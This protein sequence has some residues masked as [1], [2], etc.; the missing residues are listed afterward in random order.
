MGK[1][2][3]EQLLLS[4]PHSPG[5][6]FSRFVIKSLNVKQSMNDERKN[7]FIERYA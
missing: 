7:P 6:S 4:V 3:G 1:N 5:L 2:M